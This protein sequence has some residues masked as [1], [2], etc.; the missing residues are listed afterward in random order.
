MDD[1]I[2]LEMLENLKKF[3]ENSNLM[4]NKLLTPEIESKMT[5]DQLE[6]INEARN[7]MNIKQGQTLKQKMEN[8]HQI[9][10]KNA[11]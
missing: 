1:K 10:N 2:T 8:L 11:T 9:L 4:F 7:S 6:L 5:E 3:S